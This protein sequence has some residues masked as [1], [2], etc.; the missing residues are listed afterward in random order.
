MICTI[1][2]DW[3]LAMTAN[4]VFDLGKQNLKSEHS[5]A[6]RFFGLP[7]KTCRFSSLA[8]GSN[9][10]RIAIKQGVI[11]TAAGRGTSRPAR[12]Y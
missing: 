4:E 1:Y 12:A 8:H 3:G 9:G 7:P 5:A 10:K 6:L 11:K 2:A